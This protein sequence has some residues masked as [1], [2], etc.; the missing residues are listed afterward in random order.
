MWTKFKR[1]YFTLVF[2][3]TCLP[4]S[5]LVVATQVSQEF[6]LQTWEKL[7]KHT[8]AASIVVFTTTDC[9][10]CPAV[11]EYL[12][13]R[14]KQ[15]KL[16]SQRPALQVVVMDGLD[17]P[18]LIKQGHYLL[19]D[20]LWVFQGNRSALQYSVNPKWRGLTPYVALIAANQAEFIIGKPE[21]EKLSQFLL[22][23][24]SP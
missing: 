19:A 5:P 13:Q 21:P 22:K 17:E 2:V 3:L 6:T 10:H 11:I 14:V 4:V 15:V 1:A 8:N 12:S 7:V 20:K 16:A 23:L 18:E 24:T 9:S